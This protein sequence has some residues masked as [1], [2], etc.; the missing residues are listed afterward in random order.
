MWQSLHTMFRSLTNH[1]NTHFKKANSGNM[2]VEFNNIDI[3]VVF[4]AY[5]IPSIGKLHCLGPFYTEIK[6]Y[7]A[8]R[9]FV[10][11]LWWEKNK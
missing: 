10:N 4:Y 9:D 1:Y 7:E 2:H 3:F 6:A 8:A 5:D 11:K